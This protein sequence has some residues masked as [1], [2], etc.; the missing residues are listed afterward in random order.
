[1]TAQS[2]IVTIM[3]RTYSSDKVETTKFVIEELNR[4][5]AKKLLPTRMVRR[6]IKLQEKILKDLV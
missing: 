5:R 2:L 6:A 3:S 1:M 4:I